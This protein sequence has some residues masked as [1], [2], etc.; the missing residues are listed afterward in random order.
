MSASGRGSKGKSK[1]PPTSSPTEETATVSDEPAASAPRTP[2]PAASDTKQLLQQV[3]LNI[4]D[5]THR[6]D[7]TNKTMNQRFADINHHFAERFDGLKHDIDHRCNVMDQR[8]EDTVEQVNRLIT[9]KNGELQKNF[10]TL[11]LQVQEH[12]ATISG[13]ISRRDAEPSSSARVQVCSPE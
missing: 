13:A 4:A 7:D 1:I 5:L 8:Q 3:L 10:S 12:T 9:E 6:L 2:S 11:R